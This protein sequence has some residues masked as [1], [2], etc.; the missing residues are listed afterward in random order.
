MRWCFQSFLSAA[1]LPGIAHFLHGGVSWCAASMLCCC[2]PTVSLPLLCGTSHI[3]T[4]LATVLPRLGQHS[5]LC[6][7]PLCCCMDPARASCCA[8]ACNPHRS[9]G[10]RWVCLVCED[11][12]GTTCQLFGCSVRHTARMDPLGSKRLCVL[13]VTAASGI[14][15]APVFSCQDCQKHQHLATCQ[16]PQGYLQGLRRDWVRLKCQS[17]HDFLHFAEL[18]ID[19]LLI[20]L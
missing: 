19:T 9:S 14:N 5:V 3:S 2:C 18:V 16:L 13:R 17:S 7:L 12:G 1:F 15:A 4:L 11:A 6:A 10:S 20:S 8:R